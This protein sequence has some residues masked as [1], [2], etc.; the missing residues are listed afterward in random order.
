M[1]RLFWS[2]AWPVIW[3]VMQLTRTK[4]AQ[5]PG[6][7]EDISGSQ[8]WV[9]YLH[10]RKS[11]GR[12]RSQLT[13]GGSWH[14]QSLLKERAVRLHQRSLPTLPLC[15]PLASCQS[16]PSGCRL[17]ISVLQTSCSPP[18]SAAAA[19]ESVHQRH[20]IFL[21]RCPLW[22]AA[23]PALHAIAVPT[24]QVPA[25]PPQKKAGLRRHKQRRQEFRSKRRQI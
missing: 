2:A 15:P 9:E 1:G 23:M 6:R 11:A 18:I 16:K 19:S 20:R 10:S 3:A 24:V 8:E 21:K 4:Q 17:G 12:C 22:P 25:A 14:P 7:E 13:G 5:T